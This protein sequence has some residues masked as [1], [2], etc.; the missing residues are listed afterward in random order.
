MT[1]A[2]ITYTLLNVVLKKQ[3]PKEVAAQLGVQES[4]VNFYANTPSLEAN[5]K[6]R[7]RLWQLNEV[8]RYGRGH[9]TGF[10]SL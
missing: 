5:Y 4:F 8:L 2:T 1:T 3:T 6:F 7:N 10:V 9:N